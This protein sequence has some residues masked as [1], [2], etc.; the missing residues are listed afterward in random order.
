M[1]RLSQWRRGKGNGY[2]IRTISEKGLYKI[3]ESLGGT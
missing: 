1:L 2:N 3:I